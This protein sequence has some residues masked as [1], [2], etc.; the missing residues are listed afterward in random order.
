MTY[1][2]E[3]RNAASSGT[4]AKRYTPLVQQLATMLATLPPVLVNR[5]WSIEELLPRLEGR[6]RQRPASREVAKALKTLGWTQ[7]RC[8][9]K[10]GLNRRFWHPPIAGDSNETQ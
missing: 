10:S 6:Y 4:S 1:L 2:S 5:P 8:W 7:R 9:K 3:L